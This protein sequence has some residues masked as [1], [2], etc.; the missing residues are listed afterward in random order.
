MKEAEW[1]SIISVNDIMTEP[2]DSTTQVEE[3]QEPVEMNMTET[4]NSW[5]SAMTFEGEEVEWPDGEVDTDDIDTIA[6]WVGAT[7]PAIV[8]S[9]WDIAKYATKSIASDDWV[10]EV[11]DNMSRLK[12]L[13]MLS[14]MKWLLQDK[15]KKR[16]KKSNIRYVLIKDWR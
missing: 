12:A 4:T 1:D 14:K 10:V 7:T 16:T 6:D 11:D 9:V 3:Y 5:Y 2:S 15:R 13:E 8:A